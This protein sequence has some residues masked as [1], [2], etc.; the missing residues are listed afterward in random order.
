MRYSPAMKSVC[1]SRAALRALAVTAIAIALLVGALPATRPSS[2][3]PPP[4]SVELLSQASA[5]G[6]VPAPTPQTRH[7]TA[8]VTTRYAAPG[9]KGGHMTALNWAIAFTPIGI[10]IL[11]IYVNRFLRRRRK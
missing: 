11:I 7:D 2:S 1:W 9:S 6:V 4:F 10:G 5:I 8:V 3:S